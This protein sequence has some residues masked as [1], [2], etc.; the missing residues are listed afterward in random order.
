MQAG[1]V[2]AGEL[3]D[4]ALVARVAVRVENRQIDP[5]EVA[6]K[7]RSIDD[8]ADTRGFEVELGR[9]RRRLPV[10]RLQVARRCVDTALGDVLVDACRRLGAVG[11]DGIESFRQPPGESDPGT[12]RVFQSAVQPDAVERQAAQID[13]ASPVAA[14]EVLVGLET[15]GPAFRM[16]VHG[17]LKQ[18]GIDG[19]VDDVAAPVAARDAARTADTE[20]HFPARDEQILDHLAARL[21]AAD[22]QDRPVRQLSGI[23]IVMAVNSQDVVGDPVV[24]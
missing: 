20:M 6:A 22:H 15:H 9:L 11:V 8:A 19:P 12:A 17:D 23:A 18:A 14:G 7:A 13:G 21:A 24:P 4:A 2:E 10:V 3:G 16:L 1:E 5:A